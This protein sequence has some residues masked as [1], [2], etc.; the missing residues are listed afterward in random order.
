MSETLPGVAVVPFPAATLSDDL[1]RQVA[2]ELEKVPAGATTAALNVQTRTGV[3]LVIASRSADG[4]MTAALWIG[5]SGWNAP[6][7]R[8]W[9]GG[10]SLRAT[11]GGP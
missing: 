9:V 11:W 8:S 5:K 10:V 3:N 1:Q 4:K 2:L 7:D 6:L